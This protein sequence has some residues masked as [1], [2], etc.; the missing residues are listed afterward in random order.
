MGR[1]KPGEYGH[2]WTPPTYT[3]DENGKVVG[4]YE[5]ARAEQLGALGRRRPA[6]HPEP[7]R[8]R[9]A[10]GRRRAGAAPARSSRSRCRSTHGPDALV[11]PGAAAAPA[12]DRLGRARRKPLQRRP[13]RASSG[14]TTCSRCPPRAPR[15]GTRFGHVMWQDSMYNGCWAGNMTALGGATLPR[16]RA[17]PRELRRPRRAPRPRPRARAS[18]SAPTT[19]P[20]APTCSTP[21]SRPRAPSCAA[22]TCCSCAPATWPS[23]GRS[24]RRRRHR[25]PTSSPRRASAAT[26]S[27]G[28]TS[29]RC[30][31]SPPTTSASSRWCRRTPRTACCPCTSPAWWTSACRSASCGTWTRSPP[32]AREDGDYEF[33]LVAPPLYLPGG[34]GSPLNPIALK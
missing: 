8:R 1:T 23:G 25:T 33:L 28:S 16:H 3:V 29:T 12:H 14:A 10:R 20:S 19:R 17:P 21:R 32:T 18:T 31:P 6:R 5:P 11:A 13:C 24:A 7:D 26:R 27:R 15:S 4:G 34:M 22:A 9:R 30:R 2:E